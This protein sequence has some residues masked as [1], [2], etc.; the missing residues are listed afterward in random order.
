[1]WVLFLLVLFALFQEILKVQQLSLIHISNDVDTAQRIAAEI[2]YPVI[3]RP[4]FTL[5]GAGG[6]VAYNEKEYID[7]GSGIGVTAFGIVDDEWKKAVI[8][9]LDKL[10]HTSNL[11]YTEP[12]AELA[13]LL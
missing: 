10:Q 3:I 8:D 13:K 12:C 6:G 1:M 4:A 11:Y 5:G 2:G 7:F 9:Q